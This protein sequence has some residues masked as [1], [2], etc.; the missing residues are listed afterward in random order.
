MINQWIVEPYM[1]GASSQCKKRTWTLLYSE[2]GIRPAS[3]GA[4]SD[5]E[6][7]QKLMLVPWAMAGD[8]E[9]TSTA[10]TCATAFFAICNSSDAALA[11]SRSPA[12]EQQQEAESSTAG[13]QHGC[14]ATERLCGYGFLLAVRRIGVEPSRRLETELETWRRLFRYRVGPK[15]NWAVNLDPA[16]G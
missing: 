14:T 4:R 11:A 7:G 13:G 12:H 8:R 15:T 3:G 10:T 5:F 2:L 1:H 6:L 16:T 9:M